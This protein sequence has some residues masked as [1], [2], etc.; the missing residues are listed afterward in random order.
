[1]NLSHKINLDVTSSQATFLSKAC[2]VARYTWNWAVAECQKSYKETGKRPGLGE[3]KKRWNQEKPEWVY[4]SPKDANQQP[5]SQLQKAFSSAF[6]RLKRGKPA[7]FPRFHKKGGRDSFYLS[8]DKIEI[9]GRRVRIPLIGWVRMREALRF[10][11]K[12]LSA[13]VS[14]AAGKWFISFSVEGDFRRGVAPAQVIGVDLG[15]KDAAVLST[16]EKLSGPKPLRK[17]LKR[18]QRLSKVVSRRRIGSKRRELAKQAVAKLH[19]RIANIRRDFQHKLTSKLCRENQAVCLEDLNVAGMTKNRRLSKA[20]VDI[21][22]AEIRRQ[23]EYKSKLYGGLVMLADRFFPSSKTC[24]NCGCVKEVLRLSERVF[25]CDDCGFELDR[26]INAALNL[27]T[28][29]LRETNARG[30]GTPARYLVEPRT[31]ARFSM[32]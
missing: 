3:L 18:L 21:G 24:S 2:G 28:L 30:Q 16:G 4:E 5:F 26:D 13:T 9:R 11:G 27:R 6:S 8:N 25:R 29:G 31:N 7:G 15:C 23:V 19:W 17:K 12:L 1:M 22:F 14:N 32:C 10:E 20:V